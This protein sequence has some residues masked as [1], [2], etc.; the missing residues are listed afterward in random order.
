MA[1][2]NHE[3]LN[4]SLSSTNSSGTM[5]Y[6]KPDSNP[7]LVG[8]SDEP[9]GPTTPAERIPQKQPVA[10]SIGGDG[11]YSIEIKWDDMPYNWKRSKKSPVP[12]A[13]PRAAE[14]SLL[15]AAMHSRGP[16]I[17]YTARSILRKPT[18]WRDGTN[19]HRSDRHPGGGW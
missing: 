7:T 8:F 16:G 10:I 1:R 6:R 3:F 17:P 11:T 18:H 5:W 4:E 13:R 14:R 12:G 9:G 15:R 2:F 19:T